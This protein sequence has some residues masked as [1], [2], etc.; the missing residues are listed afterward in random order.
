MTLWQFLLRIDKI[1]DQ[2]Q[3]KNIITLCVASEFKLP[4]GQHTRVIHNPLSLHPLDR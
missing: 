1:D 2:E 4:F 3:R